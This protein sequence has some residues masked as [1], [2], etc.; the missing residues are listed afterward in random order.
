MFWK[1]SINPNNPIKIFKMQKI[2]IFFY[3][4]NPKKRQSC[5]EAHIPNVEK[6]VCVLPGVIR[7]AVL[8]T[9]THPP[10]CR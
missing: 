5:I 2:I 9:G 8:Q 7:L 10:A 1:N 3:S 4:T 6:S